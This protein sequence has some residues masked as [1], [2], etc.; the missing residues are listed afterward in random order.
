MRRSVSGSTGLARPATAKRSSS[1]SRRH[2]M[3][4]RRRGGKVYRPS[5]VT[6]CRRVVWSGLLAATGP[7]Q[8]PVPS[9]PDRVPAPIDEIPPTGSAQIPRR[10]A[11]R[12][13][14]SREPAD[15]AARSASSP[16]TS[17]ERISILVREEIEFTKAKV[18]RRS[19]TVHARLRGGD[20]RRRF[21]APRPRDADVRVAWLLNDVLGIEIGLVRSSCSGRLLPGRGDRR[22]DRSAPDQGSLLAEQAIEEAKETRA[23]E[24]EW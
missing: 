19:P 9:V 11:T 17:P 1:A 4:L 21:A 12:S 22:P 5:V 7:W 24:R 8:H 23:A 2:L 14:R 15:G 13:A 20:R 6:T 10:S 16:S 3:V 18:P